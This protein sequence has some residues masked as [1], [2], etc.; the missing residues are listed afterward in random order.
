MLKDILSFHGT[1]RS[2]QQRV[3][4]Q[5]DT[6]IDDKKM[7][8]V[9]APGSG[10]T[11]LGIEILRRINQPTLVL[12]PTIT[13]REQWISRISEAFLTVPDAQQSYLSQ[14]LKNPGL[15]TVTT[16]QALY[17][18]MTKYAGEIS[19]EETEEITKTENVDYHNFDVVKL[20]QE[21]KLG[22]ICL[23]EC[24]H[25]RSE[26][27]R[28]LEE[29]KKSFPDIFTVSL[30]ATPPYDSTPTMWKRYINMC[31]EIDEE[32][33]V[34]EL[35]KEGTLCPHQDF[36]YF[37]YPTR[38]EQ[39]QIK[40]FRQNANLFFQDL[41][42]SE[43]FEAAIKN[44]KFFTDKIP[45]DELL[46]DSEYL[47]AMIIFLNAKNVKNANKYQKLL[48]YKTVEPMSIT[49]MEVLLQRFL[50]EDAESYSSYEEFRNQ[51]KKDLKS[52]GLIE[53]KTVTLELNKSLKNL[54]VHSVGK[55]ESIKAITTHEFHEMGENLRLLILT[56]YI[57][58]EY[59]SALGDETKDVNNLGVLPF[60]ELLR[61]ES[62][63]NNSSM[64]LGVLCGSM[65]IIPAD[66]KMALLTLV[67]D[68]KRLSFRKVGQLSDYVKVGVT[69]NAHFLT[70]AITELF[71][72]GHIHVLIGTKSLLGEG[73]DS[74]CINSLILAS[75]VGSYMLSNQ[76]RGRAIRVL[77]DHPE[78]TS[79][80]WH[81]VCIG[82]GDKFSHMITNTMSEDFQTLL[83]RMD[84]FMGL[85]YE[86]DYIESGISRIESA[87]TL[88]I[89]HK[90]I[91][92]TNQK[93]LSLSSD[94]NSLRERWNRSLAIYENMEVAETLEV[95][96]KR[97]YPIC[98]SNA[99]RMITL[100]IIGV[101][102]GSIYAAIEAYNASSAHPI[103]LWLGMLPSSIF[104]VVGFIFRVKKF[105]TFR[106]PLASL[107]V[108][109][110]GIRDALEYG[111]HFESLNNRV[112][113]ETDALIIYLLGGTGHDKAL[114]AKCV[115]EFFSPIDNQRYIL[116][117]PK[118]KKRL[119]GYF[120]VPEV[121]ST[122]K[123][124]ALSFAQSMNKYTGNY[125]LIY[126]R[127]EAGRQILLKGRI[128]GLANR[129]ERCLARKKLKGALD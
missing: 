113:T 25:L 88:P 46:A 5:F 49:R 115:D 47:S 42:H 117:N 50:Y 76:M 56:D 13:I 99:L 98:L 9:A 87:I 3:L 104:Y 129:H 89:T 79:N 4:D 110:L 69:G 19:E 11:T 94:R 83:R 30:T 37:N 118:H 62:V 114:F 12:A 91:E 31:G 35:V 97:I 45:T 29:F 116:Y 102:L 108:Y 127:N 38:K 125:Q 33:T 18:A 21:H 63:H 92:L 36:V 68:P 54:L 26:W 71:S 100:L 28:S 107:K 20:F 72:Q 24:H 22:A 78:K 16:Y 85:D 65:V 59:E 60:F 51:L 7:H 39:E 52:H 70:Q 82:P 122:R 86:N 106:N 61:R 111:D 43:I 66:A 27:W 48:G 84:N 105:W 119:D 121:F 90:N 109:G 67:E 57:R 34:P 64:K 81:L 101:I 80:I 10:K 123:E 95:P 23:D 1:W 58:K 77:K 15:L 74:P 53:R 75:F 2:Y 93:M 40:T 128:Y 103:N 8:I 41:M 44:H 112:K 126:T 32:I 96:E 120:P 17:S 55:C 124:D 6:Y 14:D 73:W